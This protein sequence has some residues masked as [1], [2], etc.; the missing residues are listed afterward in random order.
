MGLSKQ[1][2]IDTSARDN[3]VDELKDA[4][5]QAEVQASEKTGV[6]KLFNKVGTAIGKGLHKGWDKTKIHAGNAWSDLTMAYHAAKEAR[7]YR[8][9]AQKRD[10]LIAKAEAAGLVVSVNEDDPEFLSNHLDLNE[11]V[12]R[13]GR[14]TFAEQNK[15][16]E[17][18]A[19]EVD[20]DE[21]VEVPDL[22]GEEN[23]V[24]VSEKADDVEPAKDE[25]VDDEE[26][27][28]V[29]DTYKA[30]DNVFYHDILDRVNDLQAL[31]AESYQKVDDELKLSKNPDTLTKKI[32]EIAQ[33][34]NA[35]SKA[36]AK[37]RHLYE[38]DPAMDD[39]RELPDTP[40]T[41]TSKG[42]EFGD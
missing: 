18:E 5:N 7:K 4:V 20:L 37:N 40:A 38:I 27:P 25:T 39:A 2:K 30:N 11:L 9:E 15:V 19:V 22:E 12:Y 8:H 29:T 17:P 31:L 42:K 24:E 13:K 35:S 28:E 32:M 6:K 16:E 23:P 14:K 10:K 34:L 41:A 21:E 1:A 3:K 26:V 36:Y 33:G